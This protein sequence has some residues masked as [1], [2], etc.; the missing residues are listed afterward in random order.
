MA[1]RRECSSP[2]V[3]MSDT[4]HGSGIAV[5]D[6]PIAYDQVPDR[7]DGRPRSTTEQVSTARNDGAPLPGAGK[8]FTPVAPDAGRRCRSQH[9]SAGRLR[10][11]RHSAA[12]R[13][14]TFVSFKRRGLRNRTSADDAVIKSEMIVAAQAL[15][16]AADGPWRVGWRWP[17]HLYIIATGQMALRPGAVFSKLMDGFSSMYPIRFRQQEPGK[18]R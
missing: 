14:R 13:M 18:L 12:G 2:V 16:P 7:S 17:R 9:V 10:R 11:P 15:D 3:P 1:Q 4:A 5:V 6:R 8:R